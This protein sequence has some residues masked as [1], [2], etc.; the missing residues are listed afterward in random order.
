MR[1]AERP[2]PQ[3]EPCL[4][5]GSVP[6]AASVPPTGLP[7]LSARQQQILALLRAGKVNKEIA[8]EL[9]IGLGTVKQHVVALFKKLGVHN[10][11]MAVSREI[12][13]R[14]PETHKV[15]S[16]VAGEGL[17]ERR[18]CIVLS[19]VLPETATASAGRLL[20]QTLASYAFDH[21][22]LFLARRGHAG[23]LIFGIQSPGEHDLFLVLRAGHLVADILAA[24]DPSSRDALRGGL[25]AGL[26]IASMNRLGGWSGEA[27]ATPAIAEAR[28]SAL[29]ATPGM[30][31]LGTSAGELLQA[32]SACG[33]VFSAPEIPLA[34]LDRLPCCIESSCEPPLGRDQELAFLEA[35]MVACPDKGRLILVEAETGMG[36]SHLCR[37]LASRGAAARWSVRHFT[38]QPD[39]GGARVYELPSGAPVDVDTVLAGWTSRAD[40]S[41]RLLIVD[42]C[43]LLPGDVLARLAAAAGA[44]CGGLMLL[45]GRRFPEALSSQGERLRLGRLSQETIEALAERELAARGMP[46]GPVAAIARI[47]TGVPLFARQLAARKTTSALPLSLRFVIGSRLD[48]LGLDRLLLRSVALSDAPVEP[49]ALAAAMGDTVPRAEAAAGLAVASGVI[50]RDEA[51]RLSFAHPLLRQAVI[52]AQVE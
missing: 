49:A 34:G 17:L 46:S 44:A 21:D 28:E 36:K 6:S 9:G 11:T 51:G 12:A 40:G 38:S 35:R 8:N 26:A 47:A 29:A 4:F 32:L 27:I 45:A 7:K 50:R 39:S 24:H 19:V 13:A 25:S 1:F 42:D 2:S 3:D 52:E 48:N 5:T 16:L 20:H 37:Y 14:T 23:D 43:H 22:A 18:P 30:L 31:R 33:T 41:A 10:R 15:S